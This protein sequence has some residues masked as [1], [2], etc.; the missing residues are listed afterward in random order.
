MVGDGRIAFNSIRTLG[1][2]EVATRKYRYIAYACS[3]LYEE[4]GVG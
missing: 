3:Y 4:M 2:E 1:L